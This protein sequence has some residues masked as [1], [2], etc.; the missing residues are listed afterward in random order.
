MATAAKAITGKTSTRGTTADPNT[1]T[2]LKTWVSL[3]PRVS[4]LRFNSETREPTVY[5][6]TGNTISHTIPWIRKADILTVLS[7]I[8]QYSD[9]V[10]RNARDVYAAATSVEPSEKKRVEDEFRNAETDLL[11]LWN[12]YKQNPSHT[13]KESIIRAEK[14]V[15]NLEESKKHRYVVKSQLYIKPLTVDKRGIDLSE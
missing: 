9:H 15:R 2:D 5:D 12:Q 1:I 8:D 7:N 3:W 6:R 13:L 11:T 4:N 14:V 10:V